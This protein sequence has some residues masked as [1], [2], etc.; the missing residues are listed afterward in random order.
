MA[1]DKNQR[2]FPSETHEKIW[3][4][5]VHLM[6]LDVTLPSEVRNL[7]PS[8]LIEGCEQMYTFLLSILQEMYERAEPYSAQSMFRFWIDLSLLGVI[9]DHKLVI[10]CGKWEESFSRD[11]S[12]DSDSF[13]LQLIEKAVIMI[14]KDK[15]G[16]IL[17]STIYPKMLYAMNEMAKLVIKG[18]KIDNS[19]SYCDFKKLCKQYK[20]DKYKNAQVFLSDEG[21]AVADLLD[22]YTKEFGLVRKMSP[23]FFG[24]GYSYDYLYK[25]THILHIICGP[26]TSDYYSANLLLELSTPYVVKQPQTINNLFFTF[27]EN[28]PD[29]FKDFFYNYLRQ[30]NLCNPKTCG[31]GDF[32][33]I[34]GKVARLC[35]CGPNFRKQMY[36]ND[37]PFIK[38]MLELRVKAI[39]EQEYSKLA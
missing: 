29:E 25:D 21:K 18:K 35:G 39:D 11:L 4:F 7:L 32:V 23:T 8:D 13:R 24:K 22:E 6:P 16:V 38:R 10:D 3:R 30:C 36:L 15:D 28:E 34:V 12:L 33:K 9:K 20:Y 26:S 5:G 27:L 17:S 37:M 2:E 1:F 14:E 31:G 19:F